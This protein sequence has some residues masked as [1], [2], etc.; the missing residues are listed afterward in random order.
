VVDDWV[1][2]EHDRTNPTPMARPCA[3]GGGVSPLAMVAVLVAAS[4]GLSTVR[5]LGQASI[6][7]A[8]TVFPESVHF[9]AHQDGFLSGGRTSGDSRVVRMAPRFDSAGDAMAAS[10]L[11]LI[12]SGTM[13]LPPPMC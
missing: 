8:L 5:L 12:R 6:G 1:L 3:A 9:E 7:L 11:L 10:R 2:K 13:D 4:S